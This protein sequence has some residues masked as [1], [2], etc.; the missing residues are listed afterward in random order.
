MKKS[1]AIDFD[2][3]EMSDEEAIHRVELQTTELILDRIRDKG[4][5]YFKLS[6]HIAHY[7]DMM[8][9]RQAMCQIEWGNV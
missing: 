3:R 2:C 8:F 4:L 7:E 9:L 6:S 1:H 5:D